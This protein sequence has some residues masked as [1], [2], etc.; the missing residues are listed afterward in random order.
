MVPLWL[1]CQV[2]Q[3]K[4]KMRRPH[5]KLSSRAAVFRIMGGNHH[6]PYACTPVIVGEEKTHA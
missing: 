3:D 6:T 4:V 1:D 2:S 5:A